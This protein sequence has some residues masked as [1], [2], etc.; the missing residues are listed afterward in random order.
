MAAKKKSGTRLAVVREALEAKE[1]VTALRQLLTVWRK[2]PAVDLAETIDET[3]RAIRTRQEP[4]GGKPGRERAERWE[5]L[6]KKKKPEDLE[7]LFEDL[8]TNAAA[9]SAVRI[10]RIAAD[11]P[12]DP[13]VARWLASV[14]ADRPFTSK[15]SGPFWTMVAET[16]V[17]I[18]DPRSLTQLL[19]WYIG[20][21]KIEKAKKKITEKYPKGPPLLPEDEAKQLS[22]IRSRLRAWAPPS[23]PKKVLAD[24]AA[25]LQAIYEAPDDVSKRLVY[26]DWLTEQGDPRGEFIQLQVQRREGKAAKGAATRERELFTEHWQKWLGGLKH[27][28]RKGLVFEGGFLDTARP[29]STPDPK[30][31]EWTTCRTVDFSDQ[32]FG[33]DKRF[34]ESPP[35]R[36]LRRIIGLRPPSTYGSDG[37]VILAGSRLAERLEVL[38]LNTSTD[39][40]DPPPQ[41]PDLSAFKQLQEL[42]WFDRYYPLFGLGAVLKHPVASRLKAFR[43]G[44]DYGDVFSLT[45]NAAGR[46]SVMRITLAKKWADQAG[47]A[48][49]QVEPGWLDE[50]HI[51]ATVKLAD[52]G[53]DDLRAQLERLKITTVVS[54][55]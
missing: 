45:R 18:A 23:T 28:P 27:L 21:N 36:N 37:T 26:A 51:T 50:L 11:H 7:L 43:G 14:C 46:L 32:A 13:R 49:R 53:R 2:V 1:L 25:L 30:P 40:R 22:E 5:A 3:S 10:R 16:L 33:P 15:N 38:G 6:A 9:D 24:G 41:I 17:E 4:L 55:L 12:R 19:A 52:E 20:G 39:L 44:N 42:W 31:I 34:T 35:L 29:N 54:P 47:K 48:L 8:I